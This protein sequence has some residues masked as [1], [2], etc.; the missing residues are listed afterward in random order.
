MVSDGEMVHLMYNK[1][2][3]STRLLDLPGR[4]GGRGDALR[5]EARREALR[6][7]DAEAGR[8]TAAKTTAT[9]SSDSDDCNAAP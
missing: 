8:V 6:L 1:I 3:V 5:Q 2:I 4:G 9:L 7:H